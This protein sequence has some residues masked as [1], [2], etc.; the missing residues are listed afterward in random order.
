MYVLDA[1]GT[2]PFKWPCDI[3]LRYVNVIWSVFFSTFD[4]LD[5]HNK[6]R[7]ALATLG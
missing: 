4:R 5:S 2:L 1:Q 3:G 6:S 7:V